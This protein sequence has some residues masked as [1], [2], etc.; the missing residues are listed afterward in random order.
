MAVTALGELPQFSN[1]A[2]FNP[3]DHKDVSFG[4]EA[5]AMRGDEFAS[6]EGL[7]R[8]VA[9]AVVVS[10]IAEMRNEFIVAIE[11]RDARFEVRNE[12]DAAAFGEMAGGAEFVINE[13]EVTT[14][15]VE[16]LEAAIA[17]IGDD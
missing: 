2:D 5:C 4:V 3:F 7:P 16:H 15:Q 12:Q 1:A 8:F 14:L 11:Q 17:A 6:F 10:T 13:A 9:N